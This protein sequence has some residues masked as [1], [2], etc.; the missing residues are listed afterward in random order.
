MNSAIS[1]HTMKRNIED[2]CVEMEGKGVFWVSG[3]FNQKRAEFW[4]WMNVQVVGDLL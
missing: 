1:D 4:K 2:F 3:N